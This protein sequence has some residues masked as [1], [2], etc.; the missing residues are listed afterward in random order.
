MNNL[1]PLE[2]LQLDQMQTYAD[3]MS[4]L[5]AASQA[6]EKISDA[7]PYLDFSNQQ[8]IQKY[9]NAL[10]KICSGMSKLQEGFFEY[11]GSHKLE[12]D[13]NLED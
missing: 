12:L 1:D 6:L 4:A 3:F 9:Y 5:E 11:A 7:A 8:M 10:G 13:Q 2:Q